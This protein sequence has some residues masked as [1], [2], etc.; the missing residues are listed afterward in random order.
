[1][2][3]LTQHISAVNAYTTG[4]QGGGSGRGPR[5]LLDPTVSSPGLW[6]SQFLVYR[7]SSTL[8]QGQE[9][10]IQTMVL[11]PQHC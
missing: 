6:L 8:G 5:A 7:S 9:W 11:L 4:G 2:L 10:M 3:V 1:M